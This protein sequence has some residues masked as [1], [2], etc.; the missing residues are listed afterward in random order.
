M[1]YNLKLKTTN[2]KKPYQIGREKRKQHST[3]QY[4]KIQEEKNYTLEVKY[5]LK[6]IPNLSTKQLNSFFCLCFAHLTLQLHLA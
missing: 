2:F 3:S 4:K 1:E 6:M 5:A